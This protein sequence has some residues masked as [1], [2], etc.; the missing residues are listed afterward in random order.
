MPAAGSILGAALLV[1]LA[2]S[3]LVGSPAAGLARPGGARRPLETSQV[4]MQP[5]ATD[6]PG[7]SGKVAWAF[8]NGVSAFD[9]VTGAWVQPSIAASS[10]TQYADTW[11]GVNGF[12]GGGPLLQTGTSAWAHDGTVSYVPWFV[13]WNGAP[14]G[15]TVIDEPVAAGDRMQAVLDGNGSGTWSVELANLTAG[16]KWSTTLSY[17]A[18]GSTAEWIEEAPGTWTTPSR[19]QTLADYGSV[20]FTTV[21]ADGAVPMT[22]TTLDIVQ[23]GS[24]VSYPSTYEP[25]QGAFTVQYGEPVPA[26]RTISPTSGPTAG[27]S[28]VVLSG[29]DLGL[30]LSPV[31]RFGGLKGT[32]LHSSTSAIVVRAPAHVPGNVTVTIS[33][34]PTAGG[35][36]LRAPS[37]FEYVEPWERYIHW[38]V[39]AS[40]PYSQTARSPGTTPPPA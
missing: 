15:M 2:L 24:V 3:A 25:A 6:D 5:P 20:T 33:A 11:V 18:D 36:V 1:T 39:P 10:T 12:D 35:T 13:D 26:V 34:G 23:S 38:R 30:S 16:W 7:W 19:Y 29:S 8:Q 22:M 4:P 17:A 31:V 40:I 28:T 14:S 21:R 37:S 32:V 27:G 9:K